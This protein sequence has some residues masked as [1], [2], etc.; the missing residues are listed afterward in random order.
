M[1][2]ST[3]T[4]ASR[5]QPTT[6]GWRDALVY[7]FGITG[8][9]DPRLRLLQP[10]RAKQDAHIGPRVTPDGLHLHVGGYRRRGGLSPPHARGGVPPA[11]G[12]HVHPPRRTRG[13]RAPRA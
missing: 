13:K 7:L 6:P 9:R 11:S 12:P 5:S 8:T 10:T 4:A 3:I 1:N 2:T